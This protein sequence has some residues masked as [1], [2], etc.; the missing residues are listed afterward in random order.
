MLNITIKKYILTLQCH[1]L[2]N[3]KYIKCRNHD[4]YA[5]CQ[6]SNYNSMQHIENCN[7]PCYNTVQEQEN[8]I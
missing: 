7:C 6:K 5:M 3:A 8:Q 4:Y 1:K 2:Y